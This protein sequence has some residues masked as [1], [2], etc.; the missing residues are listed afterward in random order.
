MLWEALKLKLLDL[1]KKNLREFISI[2][3]ALEVLSTT[4]QTPLSYVAAFLISQSFETN[5]ST[6]NADKYYVIH[7][8]D[9]WNWGKFEYTYSILTKLADDEEYKHALIFDENNIPEDVTNTY[10]KRSELYNLDL[11]K[12]LSIDS[13]FRAEDIKNIV[14]N[15]TLNLENFESNDYFSDDDVKQILKTGIPSYLTFNLEK[16]SLIDN[17]VSS[18]LV[19]FDCS[20]DKG[21]TIKKDELKRLFINHKI[22]IKGFN[23]N[24][25]QSN[26]LESS[27]IWDAH[28]LNIL[29]DDAPD[30][31]VQDYE[32]F[33]DSFTNYLDESEPSCIQDENNK[34]QLANQ[35]PLHIKIL[36]MNDFFT[37]VESACFISL[38]EPEKMQTHIDSGDLVYNAWNYGEHI[39]AVKIIENGIRA[40][41]LDIEADG[42][43]PRESLQRFLCG[44]NHVITGFN[45]NLSKL[46][47]S[48]YGDP[49]IG[50]TSLESYQKERTQLLKELK[51]LKSELEQEKLQS[52]LLILD[53]QSSQSET[54]QLKAKITE[55]E[56]EKMQFQ[57]NENAIIFQ[58][59]SLENS[60]LILVSILFKMLQDE[61]KIKSHKSQAKILQKIEDSHSHIKGLSKSRTDKLMGK[62]NKLYK[63]L[64]NIEMQ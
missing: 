51:Q 15:R 31:E 48:R 64:N 40:N 49:S 27:N 52:S 6:Y 26:P 3:E 53:N 32:L 58:E 24:L 34:Q 29:K 10:W 42:M 23:D 25:S 35:F 20:Y 60:D 56:N 28:Y 45:D 2:R 1:A 14:G 54:N 16:L 55:L 4:Q 36:A 5:I 63:Q 62:A 12:N 39:Q 21:F 9:D 37:V 18:I 46:D 30:L 19:F 44:R 59:I 43:I 8:N 38:D 41:K 11:I 7:S 17:Y 57:S 50:Y 22:I 47:Q 33:D 13:Y 61:I